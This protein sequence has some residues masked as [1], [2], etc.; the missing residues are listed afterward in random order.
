ML[1]QR[2]PHG[3]RPAPR[4]GG[5]LHLTSLLFAGPVLHA[6]HVGHTL[7]HHLTLAVL[8]LSVA[9]HMGRGYGP[10]AAPAFYGALDL[11]DRVV[12]HAAFAAVC[13]H[14]ALAGRAAALA[15]PLCAAAV[16][17]CE[18]WLARGRPALQERL[19]ALLHLVAVAGFHL[20]LSEGAAA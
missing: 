16:W 1:R 7:Y 10:P 5:V 17:L 11:A 2:L 18:L 9:A 12:A 6:F 13:A 19:H 15:V 3:G 20:L 4:P 8:T 14:E